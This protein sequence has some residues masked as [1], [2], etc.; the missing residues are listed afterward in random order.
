MERKFV[1]YRD[2]PYYEYHDVD[3][4]VL[5]T[6]GW[7]V[8]YKGTI[9]HWNGSAWSA[10]TSPT[11]N[12]LTSI[13]MVS[14]ND[15]WAVGLGAT[16]TGGTFLRWNGS[17]WSIFDNPSTYPLYSVAMVSAADGWAT[18]W[19]SATWSSVILRWNGS[20]WA[21]WILKSMMQA[22]VHWRWLDLQMDGP[23]AV[24][25]SEAWS[26]IGMDHMEPGIVALRVHSIHVNR[27]GEKRSVGWAPGGVGYIWRYATPNAPPLITVSHIEVS[28]VVQMKPIAFLLS[29]VSLHLYVCT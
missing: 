17:A 23:L 14:A 1:E 4:M 19:S 20:I 28:Q 15:G 21:E 9:L 10:V 22:W 16:S 5:A 8:G 26:Y 2:H 11:T 7:A 24:H 25:H 29:L 27:P 13:S 12:T 18:T 6:N 3:T